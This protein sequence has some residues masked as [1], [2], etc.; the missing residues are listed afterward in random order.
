M[1]VEIKEI[2][3]EKNVPA[4]HFGSNTLK[5]E[6]GKVSG[7]FSKAKNRTGETPVTDKDGNAKTA[8]DGSP[9]MQGIYETVTLYEATGTVDQKQADMDAVR[10]IVIDGDKYGKER[11]SRAAEVTP[12]ALVA[13]AKAQGKKAFNDGTKFADAEAYLAKLKTSD[14]WEKTEKKI[15]A[16]MRAS[17]AD[18]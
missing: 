13:V 8:K 15:L 18:I 16:F 14:N 1:S 3:T 4:N 12:D 5:V 11:T 10:C 17:Q 9:V 2:K 7:Q 6:D